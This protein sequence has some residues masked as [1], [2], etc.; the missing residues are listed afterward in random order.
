ML[1]LR[2]SE[3]GLDGRPGIWLPRSYPAKFSIVG[4]DRMFF[5]VLL[6]YSIFPFSIQF[7]LGDR[8]KKRLL[9]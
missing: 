9:D 1:V 2:R 6:D 7:N 8:S 3:V 5:S 4:V